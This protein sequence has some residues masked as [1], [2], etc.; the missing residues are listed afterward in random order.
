MK[1][2][3]ER[4]GVSRAVV[5]GIKVAASAVGNAVKDYANAARNNPNITVR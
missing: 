3:D 2:W 4:N 1:E 5:N